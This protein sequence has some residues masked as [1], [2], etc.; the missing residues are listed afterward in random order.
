MEYRYDDGGRAEAGFRGHAGDCVTRAVA[1]ATGIPYAEVYKA[2]AEG[3]AGERQTKRRRGAKGRI[4]RDGIHT[5]RK[6][7]K[8]YMASIGWE[9]VPTMGIGTGCKVHLLDGELPSGALIVA[10]SR[11]YTAVVDGVVRDT[12]DPQRKT[13]WYDATGKVERISHRCVYGYWRRREAANG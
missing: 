7:F 8:D 2:L 9:W 6:W 11:H 3:N 1:I 5:T 13:Y 12:H 4:A 10:V